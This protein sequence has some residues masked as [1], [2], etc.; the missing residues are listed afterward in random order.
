[1]NVE[2]RY[3]IRRY[4]IFAPRPQASLYFAVYRYQ[5]AYQYYLH[6]RAILQNMLDLLLV[7][8]NLLVMH[9]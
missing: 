5:A 4:S 1:M 7:V 8:P 2:T 3:N 9:T 6:L